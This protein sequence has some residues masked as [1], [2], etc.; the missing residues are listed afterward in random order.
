MRARRAAALAALLAVVAPVVP[1][2]LIA[3]SWSSFDRITD[4]PR[5][6]AAAKM[7][8]AGQGKDIYR[9]PELAS[10]EQSTFPRLGERVM[11]FYYPPLALPWLLPLAAVP[12]RLAPWLWTG[13]LLASTGG[14]LF[15]LQRAFALGWTEVLCLW[16]VLRIRA[17]LRVGSHRA[18][19]AR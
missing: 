13:L 16:A 1:A 17:A 18:V 2:L 3:G 5:F 11:A 8:V 6:F 9:L 14:S 19:G 10:A 15:A 4:L 12:A 7:M